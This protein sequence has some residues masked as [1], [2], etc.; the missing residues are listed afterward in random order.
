E[1]ERSREC[2][3]SIEPLVERNRGAVVM[4][5]PAVVGVTDAVKERIQ[6]VQGAVEAQVAGEPVSIGVR[7]KVDGLR[8]QVIPLQY[9]VRSEAV[10]NAEEAV[11][12]IGVPEIRRGSSNIRSRSDGTAPL[13]N[14]K[15]ES[16]RYQTIEWGHV[17]LAKPVHR[18]RASRDSRIG[19][20]P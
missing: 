10:L 20:D 7:V 11:D 2:V 19:G 6:A 3:S 14:A 18:L 4:R 17:E 13:V 12:C 9:P 1:G 16:R 5:P 15:C 8:P